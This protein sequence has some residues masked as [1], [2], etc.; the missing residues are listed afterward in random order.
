M[1]DTRVK[2]IC[3]YLPQ[4]HPVPENNEWWGK[5]FTEWRN[6]V[7]AKPLFPDHYQP[8]LPTDLG[9][10]DLR[11]PEVREAQ[12][13]LAREHGI[14]GFCYYHYWF[15]GRRILERPFNEVLTS[16]KPDFPFCL[17][18]ANENWTRVW[19]GGE[20][21]VLLEQQYS[22]EDDLAHIRSL[23]PAFKDPRYIRIDGKPV[24]LVYRTGILPNPLRTTEIW[25]EAVRNAGIEDLYLVRVESHGDTTNP[26][27]IGFDASMEFAPFNGLDISTLFRSWIYR[28]LG[29]AGVFPSGLLDHNIY[30]YRKVAHSMMN[31]PAPNFKRFHC[32]TPGWDNTARRNKNGT[33][34]IDATPEIY[35][36][37]LQ[38]ATQ[39]TRDE[40][41]G[42]E[43]ICFVNAWNEWAEGNHL[44]PD[45]KWGRAYLEATRHVLGSTNAPRRVA[46][47]VA[48]VT[49]VTF[50]KRFYWRMATAIFGGPARQLLRYMSLRGTRKKT[51]Y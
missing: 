3:F 11:L 8:H 18:W 1:P 30:E 38:T 42:D 32:V 21:N 45:L 41:Q 35:G 14:H 25:R 33:I 19:D 9:F 23:I 20:R 49:N 13:T 51:N 22:H 31:R 10:Y 28:I 17:C 24:F 34:L 15:N 29:K 48:K 37:W 27:E 16:G 5:G 39:R 6:V 47:T 2:T 46:D 12:A 4:F 43:Q 26:T 36:N 50:I 40:L 7:K 44:E